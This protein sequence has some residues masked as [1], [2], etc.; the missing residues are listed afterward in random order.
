MIES[1][2]LAA[3]IEKHI[4]NA[5][6]A[7][8][9]TYVEKTI[10]ALVLDAAWVTK[11]E[12]LVNQNFQR[13]FSER[14]STIDFNTLVGEHIDQGI[15]RW[16]TRLKENFA[17][18][19]ITD[20]ATE[21]QV[22]VTDQSVALEKELRCHDLSVAR[23]AQ[24]RGT[25]TVDNLAL[26]GSIN[27]DNASWQ[28]LIDH[29]A[30]ETIKQMNEIWQQKLCQQVLDLAKQ[31]G[32]DFD[33]ITLNGNPLV[34]GNT[35]NAQIQI[36]NLQQVGDLRSLRVT[37]EAEINSTLTVNQGRIGVNTGTPEM[38]LGI[39]D[40]EVSIIA[41]K[42]KQNQA[43]IGTSR[44]QS[45]AIG[46]N[47]EG[48]ITVDTDGMVTVQKFRIN[49]HRIGFETQVPGYGGTRGDIVFNSDPKPGQPFAWQ[50]LGGFKWQ[51]LRAPQ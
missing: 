8:I 47:R 6:D 4:K 32:I 23:D 20:L 18:R 41:G 44:A 16:Q 34:Q 42:H 48:H 39:W 31:D 17:T 35:L 28:A 45:L 15:E 50:C 43:F 51:T 12:N 36:S 29:M 5:V 26:R 19:G 10:A 49:Q 27:T 9:E 22:T 40:E 14:L 21:T 13:R 7:S 11:V 2:T 38:A 24:V 3:M 33:R 46:V 37:G 30:D 1:D 25:L